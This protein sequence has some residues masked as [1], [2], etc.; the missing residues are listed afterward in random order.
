MEL[1]ITSE[2]LA[3]PHWWYTLGVPLG[4]ALIIVRVVAAL[5]RTLKE[6]PER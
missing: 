1:K 4:A 5:L 6:V 3:I 2:A